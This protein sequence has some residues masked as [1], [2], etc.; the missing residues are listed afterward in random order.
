ML[1][2]SSHALISGSVGTI[3][4]GALPSDTRL[5]CRENASNC[6]IPSI[7]EVWYG[8]GN[9][10]VYKLVSGNFVCTN[11][12]FSDPALNKAKACY[13]RDILTP[14]ALPPAVTEIPLS[15]ELN[16]LLT[17]QQKRYTFGVW[18]GDVRTPVATRQFSIN[19]KAR[20]RPSRMQQNYFQFDITDT[21][22]PVRQQSIFISPTFDRC[23]ASGSSPAGN[24]ETVYGR[25]MEIY[26]MTALPASQMIPQR[27]DLQKICTNDKGQL[28]FHLKPPSSDAFQIKIVA[29]DAVSKAN[30]VLDFF[31]PL[32]FDWLSK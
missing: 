28:K 24:G 17:T 19:L 21:A 30:D 20:S 25:I 23:V 32:N 13:S 26:S 29:Y 4:N 14:A 1:V 12:N 16:D 5:I 15:F 2:G 3:Y 8:S 11:E 6:S 18:D 7:Q 9:S 31:V 10:W 27:S 22:S